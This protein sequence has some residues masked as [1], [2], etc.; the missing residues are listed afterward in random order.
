[1][2][3]E[4][5]ATTNHKLTD[6]SSK[7]TVTGSS[8]YQNAFGN[9]VINSTS[10]ESHCWQFKILRIKESYGID[11]GICME[12]HLHSEPAFSS[13]GFGYSLCSN[14]CLYSANSNK[15][16]YKLRNSK[17]KYKVNDVVLVNLD[18]FAKT[19]SFFID[20]KD[21]EMNKKIIIKN[22]QIDENIKYRMA[23][24]LS[25]KKDSVKLLN[26]IKTDNVK[27]VQTKRP[28]IKC[29]QHPAIINKLKHELLLKNKEN[30]D[31]RSILQH[32][33]IEFQ[34][35][36]KTLETELDEIQK[37]N[38]FEPGQQVI[39]KY[40]DQK[41]GVDKYDEQKYETLQNELVIKQNENDEY[42]HLLLQKSL[43]ID[44]L[45]NIIK[46]KDSKL[47]ETENELKTLRIKL[48]E[49]ENAKKSRSA[50][51][52]T[53]VRNQRERTKS[54]ANVIKSDKS[55]RIDLKA[56]D[57]NGH[58]KRRQSIMA[59]EKNKPVSRRKQSFSE[60]IET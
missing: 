8:Y 19:L 3:L 16:N 15:Q 33:S 38:Q 60:Q 20:R 34:H 46:Q 30:D 4:F 9:V 47:I 50:N 58:K 23:V 18:L 17:Q 39:D 41:E 48:K 44:D 55:W 25:S 42:Q 32:K 57:Q 45:H 13:K 51:I 26:H 28:C 22:I 36:I 54:R 24:Y 2:D 31:L 59:L 53:S 6:N 43:E 11:I 14:G 40:D 1:M 21:N 7:I 12:G 35:K 52:T 29:T 27:K 56:D 37:T 10:K 49:M 5:F